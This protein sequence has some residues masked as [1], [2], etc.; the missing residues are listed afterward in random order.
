MSHPTD[1]LVRAMTSDVGASGRTLYGHFATFN[2][3]YEIDSWFEGRF[4]ESIAPGAFRRAFR[5][6]RDR[7]RVMFNHGTDPSIGFKP[8]GEPTVL[9]EDKTGPY[10]EA[11]LFDVPYVNDLLP[12]L[13]AGQFGASF[14]FRVVGEEWHSP[15]EPASH[16]PE[17]LD[18]RTITDVDLW[19]FGP[20]VWG[21]NPAATSGVRSLT[22]HYMEALL[23]DPLFVARFTERA[24]LTV[25]EK[26]LSTV[27]SRDDERSEDADG[28]QDTSPVKA[29]GQA[30]RTTIHA[31]I[32]ERHPLASAL[33]PKEQEQ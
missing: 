21:A 3:W 23:N 31:L 15:R 24:G 8:L 4:L 2:D 11:D 18:E 19:E 28:T 7:L 32:A 17:M 25:V 14:K 10:Y 20:V 1:N 13:R 12:A 9:R 27:P 6:Q 26:V 16:N 29:D 30:G 33:L 22:D 5:E